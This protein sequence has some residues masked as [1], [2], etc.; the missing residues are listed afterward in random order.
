MKF[1]SLAQRITIYTIVVMTV[2]SILGFVLTNIYYHI[3]LKEKND[4]KVMETLKKVQKYID[5]DHEMNLD[6]YLEHLSELH[7]QAIIYDDKMESTYYGDHFRK[8][9]LDEKSVKKVLNGKTYHGIK[10]RPFNIFIT[11]FF[12]NETRN[13]VGMKINHQGSEYALFLRPSVGSMLG[14]FRIFLAI[15]LVLLVVIS[16]VLVM[17][18]SHSLANPIRRLM[19]TTE[20]LG[21][22]DFDVDIKVTRDDEIGILQHRFIKM[23][24]EL[25][26]LETMRQSFVQNVSHE[27]K[28]PLQSILSLLREL[29]Y[30]KN[31]SKR[32][33][34]IEDIYGRA[35]RLSNLTKQLLL[36]SELD[37]SDH[38]TFNE[39]IE[40]D[41]VIKEVVRNLNYLLDD[42]EISIV[43]DMEEITIQGNNKLLYQAFYNILNNAIKYSPE[44][45]MIQINVSKQ[46]GFINVSFIDEGYGMT[47]KQLSQI[48]DRF[49]KGDQSHNVHVD[50]NGLGLSIVDSIIEHHNAQIFFE[51]V[52]DEGTKVT[53]LF[54]HDE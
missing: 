21:K 4:Y 35:Y 19:N 32:V 29:E 17:F 53:I 25:K 38:L 46:D 16:L 33:Q 11:G 43:F 37:N 9:N 44:Y 26:Q 20:S 31:E 22:G 41:K 42:K 1:K 18:S 13:T 12:D 34:I 40:L 28:S 3:D 8:Y 27:I 39:S 15:L 2:S 47:Q 54:E 6:T 14:E 23:R 5:H 52:L 24:D 50:S 10:E 7:Y 30:E 49:Y 48:R 36:L 45:S 51:S